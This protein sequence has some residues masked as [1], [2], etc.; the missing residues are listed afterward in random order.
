MPKLSVLINFIIYL[1][2]FLLTN[3]TLG[4]SFIF[5]WVKLYG[6]NFVFP[7]FQTNRIKANC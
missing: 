6:I 2:V 3:F 5:Y 1:L 7:A 4:S